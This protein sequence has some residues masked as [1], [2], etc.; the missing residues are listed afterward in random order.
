MM[1]KR[2]RRR[3]LLERPVKFS[4]L[5]LLVGRCEQVHISV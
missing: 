4:Y 2:R 3:T 1:K 5:V